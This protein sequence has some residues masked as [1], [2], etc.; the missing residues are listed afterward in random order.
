M[1]GNE[2]DWMKTV[3]LF[4]A[5]ISYKLTAITILFNYVPGINSTKANLSFSDFFNNYCISY[6][7]PKTTPDRPDPKPL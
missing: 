2:S 5:P 3:K 4:P 6:S 1:S 7:C